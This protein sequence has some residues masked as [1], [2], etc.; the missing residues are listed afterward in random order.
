MLSTMTRPT[1][2]QRFIL[3]TA[4][5]TLMVLIPTGVLVKRSLT[6]L[7]TVRAEIAGTLPT[8][9]LLETLNEVQRHR[10]LSLRRLTGDTTVEQSRL[11]SQAAVT[12][13][14]ER[15]Q[16]QFDSTGVEAALS[17]STQQASQAFSQLAAEVGRDNLTARESFTRH[18]ELAAL[19]DDLSARVLAYSGL[20]RD[21]DPASYFYIIAGFQEGKA[22]VEL[23][24]Q[25]NDLGSMV[26]LSKGATP[27]D[28]NQIA[29]VRA[30]LQDRHRFFTQN[31]LLAEQYGGR[32]LT[33]ALQTFAK[34]AST[35]LQS[36][37]ALAEQTFL[38]MSPDWTLEPVTFAERIGS[39]MTAQRELTA[40]LS[41]SVVAELGEREKRLTLFV[42]VLALALVLMLISSAWV[43]YRIIL[44]IM[45]PLRN[46]V[47]HAE[48]LASGDLSVSFASSSRDEIGNLQNTLDDM[49]LRW[50]ALVHELQATAGEVNTASHEI[51]MGNLDLSKRT[52]SAAAQLQQ[53]AGSFDSLVS[54][55]NMASDSAES[56]DKLANSAAAVAHR[57]K[58]VMSEVV[59]TMTEIHG[60]SRKIVEIISVID[61]IAFQ[62]NILALNAAVEAARAG[63]Q[64]RGFAVVA[65]EVRIL[66]QRSAVAAR[67]IKVL[68][69]SSVDR[70]EMGSRLV[71]DAGATMNEIVSSVQ[72]VGVIVREIAH[73][74]S[75]QRIGVGEVSMAVRELDILTQQNAALV[76]QSG[77]ATESLSDQASRLV[78]SV[79]RFRL[80]AGE[81]GNVMWLAPSQRFALS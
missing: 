44:S 72:G 5:V 39:V 24:A 28:L 64:G 43:I 34:A 33:P 56:A 73:A 2:V 66:A 81:T 23:L 54:A 20:L 9:Q 51:A 38:G 49:R 80:S 3:L 18:I 71:A 68:I 78:G 42:T 7:S 59:S 70:V 14:L 40:Q 15:L 62:T 57:G 26:L 74:A 17:T 21:T 50:A 19:L 25:L 77:A 12:K 79:G 37:I 36:A 11:A 4:M 35:G 48:A 53:A 27:L 22:V 16:Q 30:T 29:A 75:A 52:E 58:H 55:L 47:R 13:L 8:M 1:I 32:A 69:G 46:S 6:E 10:L 45:Q 65:S 63:E 61:S 41:A 67:E 76:E 60:S 31:L